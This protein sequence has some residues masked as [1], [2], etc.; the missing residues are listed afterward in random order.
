ML[1]APPTN[2][3]DASENLWNPIQ[4]VGWARFP[5]LGTEGWRVLMIH[6]WGQNWH[7]RDARFK[8]LYVTPPLG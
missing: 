1:L 6:E 2:A 8:R 4:F 3:A 5:T 7:F